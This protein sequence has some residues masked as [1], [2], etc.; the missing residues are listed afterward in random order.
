MQVLL[1]AALRIAR[2]PPDSDRR[3]AHR[4]P[5]AIICGSGTVRIRFRTWLDSPVVSS[6]LSS[7]AI[8][9][10]LWPADLRT[11]PTGSD[12]ARNPR[13]ST[14]TGLEWPKAVVGLH[15]VSNSMV[16]VV[17]SSSLLSTA[18]V[19]PLSSAI[20][21]QMASPSPPQ[22]ILPPRSTCF[23]VSNASKRWR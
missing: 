18:I 9:G 10:V 13:R 1:N 21:R 23:D 15:A 11:Q 20:C 12:G 16:N 22:R 6:P 14:T 8:Y 7:V 2:E 3:P 4:R 17:P 19:P 5:Q